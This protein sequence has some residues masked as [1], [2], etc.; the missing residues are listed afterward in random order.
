MVEWN[1]REGSLEEKVDGCHGLGNPELEEEEEQ[2]GR[3]V[4]GI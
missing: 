3:A 2:V 1:I 4:G